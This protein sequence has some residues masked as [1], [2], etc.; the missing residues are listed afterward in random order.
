MGY[1]NAVWRL[2]NGAELHPFPYDYGFKFGPYTLETHVTPYETTRL[3][4]P[5]NLVVNA[6][7][8]NPEAIGAFNAN[9]YAIVTICPEYRIIERIDIRY[10][11]Y[12]RIVKTNRYDFHNR[13]PEVGSYQFVGFKRTVP[14]T[15][16][17]SIPPARL[18]VNIDTFEYSD[19]IPGIENATIDPPKEL[20]YEM[21]DHNA[22]YAYI[23]AN[24]QEHIF[25]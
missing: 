20:F 11:N 14:I 6:L 15:F 23:D 13:I 9:N 17:S 25:I 21:V 8:R 12:P 2:T 22:E 10:W 24:T 19:D 1:N 16:G 3:I 7:L 18:C 4:L 5:F